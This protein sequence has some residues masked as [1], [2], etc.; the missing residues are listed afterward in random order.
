MDEQGSRI[1]R[2]MQ[3]IQADILLRFHDAFIEDNYCPVCLGE[4][5]GWWECTKCDYDG[6]E[7]FN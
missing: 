4:L 5:D 3:E 6:Y 1:E 2:D 7:H